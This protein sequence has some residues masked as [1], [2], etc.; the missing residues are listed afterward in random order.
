MNE[1]SVATELPIF[2]GF[3][4][5]LRCV[6]VPP[7]HYGDDQELKS[8]SPIQA[9]ADKTHSDKVVSILSLSRHDVRP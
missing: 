4:V 3:N 8:T 2:R 5:K 1:T 6:F 7:C 9:K